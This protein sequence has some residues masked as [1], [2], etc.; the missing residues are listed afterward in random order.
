MARINAL[1]SPK[2]IYSFK[3]TLDYVAWRGIFYVRSWPRRPRMPRSLPSQ[4]TAAAF[5]SLARALSSMAIPLQQQGTNAAQ[6]T[7]WTWR[8]MATRGQYGSLISWD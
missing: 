3:G 1:P 6:G 5:G 7:L 8:D 2:I 4:G